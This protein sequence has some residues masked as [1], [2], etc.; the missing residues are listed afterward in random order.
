MTSSAVSPRRRQS[1]RDGGRGQTKRPARCSLR[2]PRRQRRRR[3]DRTHA[4]HASSRTRRRSWTGETTR[5]PQPVRTTNRARR[6][7]GP[8]SLCRAGSRPKRRGF[9]GGAAQRSPWVAPKAKTAIRSRPSFKKRQDRRRPQR[10]KDG[11]TPTPKARSEEREEEDEEEANQSNKDLELACAAPD[12]VAAGPVALL[13]ATVGDVAAISHEVRQMF[14]PV[15]SESRASYF[16][17]TV[18]V[19]A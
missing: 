5:A 19:K 18:G 11:S 8:G 16:P 4:I 7:A 15:P 3:P 1:R 17:L 2:Q 14:E 13:G 6:T 10:G 9:P 12:G